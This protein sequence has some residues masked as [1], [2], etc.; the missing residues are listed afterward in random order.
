L[1]TTLTTF[2]MLAETEM[3]ELLGI[4]QDVKFA[5]MIPIGW[6]GRDFAKVKRKP[7]R[8]AIHWDGWKGKA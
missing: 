2:Q 7:V 3:R 1:G 8:E 5:A 6:P 4:P